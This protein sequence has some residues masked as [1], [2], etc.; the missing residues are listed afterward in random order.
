[1]LTRSA[2]NPLRDEAGFMEHSLAFA[3]QIASP[4]Y[5]FDEEAHRTLILEETRRCL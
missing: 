3:R 1:M 4:G 2:P 5:P